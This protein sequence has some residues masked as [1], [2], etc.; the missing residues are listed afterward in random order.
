MKTNF[1]IC[2]ESMQNMAS[3][4]DI[5]KVGWSKEQILEWLKKPASSHTYIHRYR[6][7]KEKTFEKVDDDG[8]I[9]E[10][11]YITI[12][13]GSVWQESPYMISGGN[14]NVH[15]DREDLENTCEWCEPLKEILA[16]YF[17]EIEP[18]IEIT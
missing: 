2:C 12:P 10:N 6:C 11:E 9:V 1:D 5:A 14:Q 18:L 13:V 7:I 17:E 16:E 15:L 8:L 3:V 4:I